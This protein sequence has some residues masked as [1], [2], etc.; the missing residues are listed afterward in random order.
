MDKTNIIDELKR[1]N[2]ILPYEFDGTYRSVHEALELYAKV[3]KLSLI[4]YCDLDLLYYLTLGSKKF[5]AK[6]LECCSVM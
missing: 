1:K 3:R 5:G 4:D 6:T 2:E